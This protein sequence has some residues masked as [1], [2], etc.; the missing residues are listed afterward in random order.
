MIGAAASKEQVYS[1]C[2]SAELRGGF[3]ELLGADDEKQ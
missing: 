1:Q 3:G 2:R